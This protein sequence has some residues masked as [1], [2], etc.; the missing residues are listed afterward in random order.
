MPHLWAY[1]GPV[2]KDS[3]ANA[4]DTEVEGSI[5]ESERFPRGGNGNRSILA[6]EI[7]STE[8]SG[9]LQ[10]MGS[11]KVEHG[12]ATEHMYVWH[13]LTCYFHFKFCLNFCYIFWLSL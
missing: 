5:P 4:G 8:E 10:S 9:G 1:H 12:L 7:P 6:Y 11:Q 13:S 3:P 2:V